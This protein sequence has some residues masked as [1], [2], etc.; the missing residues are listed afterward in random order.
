MVRGVTYNK[1][2]SSADKI[3]GYLPV[4]RANNIQVGKLVFSDLVYVPE[5]RISHQQL[6]KAG[7]VV[8]AM[9]SG[10]KS[11]VG[12]AA[13]AGSDWAGAF[14]AFCGVL[15]P[16]SEIDPRYFYFFTQSAE[17]RSRVSELSA[18]V[19]INNLKP[20]HFELIELPIAPRGEQTRIAQKLDELLAQVDTLK[21]RIDAI[22]VLLKEFRQSV[23]S[24]AVSGRLTED[25]RVQ[26]A[27]EQPT[28]TRLTTSPL[29]L[30]EGYKRL[31][32]QKF[33]PIS[34]EFT[35][36]TVPDSWEIFSIAELYERKAII[37]FA[38]GNHGSLY[39]RNEEFGESG[40]IFLTAKQIDDN[41]GVS[42]DECPRLNQE[43]ASQLIKG[44]AASGDV[45]LTHNATVGRVG[46]L[47][48]NEPVLLGTSVTF[49][50]FH[51]EAIDR[52]YARVFF[53]SH[54]FQEQLEGTMEQTTRNQVPIT[55][56]IS[57][58]FICPPVK[59]QQEISRRVEHLFAIAA[60]LEAKI[61]SAQAR[62]NYLT[63]SILAKAFR[64]EL[65]PQ[66]PGD[67]PASVLLERIK[68]QRAAPPKAKRGRKST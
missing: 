52:G 3:P 61:A 53:S 42:L 29:S 35:H 59:E 40:A 50:R 23:L 45:L 44:W 62:I 24:A 15:R 22:P 43:K 55:A 6:I 57:L 9:S 66:D 4:L 47:T 39:P 46:I 63:Q 19:N 14:G 36:P 33:K 68:V 17:Y 54:T 65:V 7:D 48:A 34:R 27:N 20:T 26:N 37:D 12:K 49:Y 11:V 8:I 56:Q 41:W 28:S 16:D 1:M 21:T 32:K 5:N 30:P 13:K 58:K 2:E 60:Q 31:S 38:D 25:W 67:E 10:S 51:Q 64:G 18:G